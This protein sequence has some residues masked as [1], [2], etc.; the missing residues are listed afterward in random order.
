Q[1][2][3]GAE[4]LLRARVQLYQSQAGRQIP[5]ARGENRRQGFKVETSQ[6]VPRSTACGRSCWFEGRTITDE[7]HLFSNPDDTAAGHFSTR[8][9]LRLAPTGTGSDFGSHPTRY[10]RTGE[11]RWVNG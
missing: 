11:E 4:Q 1:S 10:H 8:V 2:G 3:P 9:L 6:R 7:R 5:Q